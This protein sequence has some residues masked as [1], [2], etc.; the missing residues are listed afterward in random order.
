MNKNPINPDEII[1]IIYTPSINQ[2]E[3]AIFK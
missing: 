3:K 2:Q 1:N